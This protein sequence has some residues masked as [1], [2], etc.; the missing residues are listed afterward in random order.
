[1][2]YVNVFKWTLTTANSMFIQLIII[3]ISGIVNALKNV[4]IICLFTTTDGVR[5]KIRLTLLINLSENVNYLR[6]ICP[7][8][9]KFCIGGRLEFC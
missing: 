8:R 3:G 9:W 1:M 6:G 4:N 2:L 5:R 7:W